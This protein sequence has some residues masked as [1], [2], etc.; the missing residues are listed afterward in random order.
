MESNTV[1][2]FGFRLRQ[3]RESCGLT[4][5]ALAK[6]IGVSKETIYRYENNTQDP[7]LERAKDLAVALHTSLDYL[8]GLE[9]TYMLRLPPMSEA[10]QNALKEF[11]RVFV[12]NLSV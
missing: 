7:S 12:E 1:Y 11:L 3:L 5:A 9:H 2:D 10:Q 8:V 6:K 4:R